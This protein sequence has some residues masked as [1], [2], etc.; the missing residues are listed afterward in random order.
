[1]DRAG[2]RLSESFAPPLVDSFGRA[3]TYLCVSAT[4]RCD[5]RCIWH[6][7]GKTALFHLK[8]NAAV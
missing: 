1:M 7:A 6:D 5:F 8:S 2:A 4:G 3:I